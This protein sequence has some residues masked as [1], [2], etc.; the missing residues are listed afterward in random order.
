MGTESSTEVSFVGKV[1]DMLETAER[2]GFQDIVRW[3]EDGT[4]FKVHK[5]KEFEASVQPRYFNQ[6]KLRSFQRKVSGTSKVGAALLRGA[7][8]NHFSL[9][10]IVDCIRVFKHSRRTRKRFVSP[11]EVR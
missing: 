8:L 3:G 1:Y 5:T 4:S 11:R 7:L 9:E 2:E 10:I 6:T